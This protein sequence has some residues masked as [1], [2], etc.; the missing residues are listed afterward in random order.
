RNPVNFVSV[1]DVAVAVARA[2]TDSSLRGQVIEVVGEN[3]SQTALAALVTAPGKQPSH[4]PTAVVWSIGT[5]LRPVRPSLARV[6]RQTLVME[7]VD[8]TADAA[9][10]HEKHPWLPF[11]PLADTVRS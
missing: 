4:I 9:A 8:L 11:T 2:A 10:S 7:R 3:L 6:A 5:L 1:E